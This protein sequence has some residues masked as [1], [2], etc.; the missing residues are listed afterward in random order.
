MDKDRLAEIYYDP[1]K[2][3]SFGGVNALSKVVN[4]NVGDWL[5]S[6]ETYTLHKP[7]RRRFRRRKTISV[8]VDHLFQIDLADLASLS[9]YNDGYRYLLTCI[10]CFSRYA[11][12]VPLK[13]KSAV[14][15]ANAFATIIADRIPTYVQS[16]KGSEFLNSTFQSLLKSHGISFYTSENDD[17]KCAL[18]ERFNRTLKT[19]MYRYFTRTN[20]LRFID[21]LPALVRSYND[22]VHSAIKMAPSLVTAQNEGLIRQRAVRIPQSKTKFA[23]GDTVRI[24]ETRRTFKKG[25]LPSWTRELF[26]VVNI[27]STN[28][29]TYSIVD[30]SGEPIKG[31]FYAEELQRVEQQDDIFKVEKILKTRKRLGKTEYFVRWL[32]YPPKFDSWVDNVNA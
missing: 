17:I 24:S 13:N 12:V 16:D 18:V 26:K 19:R 3:G 27:L 7:V 21:V 22:T 1:A 8:G 30:Y 9:R 20:S 29:K 15:V 14:A 10:D 11:W 28:P 2:V 4:G 6:Q 31:K 5:R 23:V 32:G 25:Y